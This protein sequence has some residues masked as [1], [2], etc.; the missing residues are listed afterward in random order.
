MLNL[1]GEALAKWKSDRQSGPVIA[2]SQPPDARYLRTPPPGALILNVF[3][4]IP[5]TDSDGTGWTPNHATGRDHMWLSEADWRS[6]LPPE[7][8]NGVTYPLNGTIAARLA[9]FHLVD[10]VRGEPDAW[11]SEQVRIAEFRLTVEDPLIG[12]IRLNGTARMEA[13]GRGYNARLQGE[14]ICD[15]KR[16]CL[17]QIELLAWG[18]AWGE[19]NYTRGAPKGQFPLLVSL[20]LAGNTPADRVPP[21]SIRSQQD[22]WGASRASW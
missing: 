14:L 13:N 2:V 8:K 16:S 12:R 7:W 10:N 22:Y 17:T 21:Q 19:G 18:E 3:T 5:H 20:S 1:I 15:R 6:L 11:R 9:R 4:R